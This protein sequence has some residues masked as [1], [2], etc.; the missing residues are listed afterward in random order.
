M[1]LCISHLCTLKII[2]KIVLFEF[3]MLPSN[4]G[5]IWMI[6][7]WYS[8]ILP[9]FYGTRSN[10]SLHVIEISYMFLKASMLW[11][12]M[13]PLNVLNSICIQIV[14][15]AAVIIWVS[16]SKSCRYLLG[17]LRLWYCINLQWWLRTFS[18]LL[19]MVRALF[20]LFLK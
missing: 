12:W 9:W 10:I 4:K 11:I 15:E 16:H 6:Y 19:F 14:T 3:F 1:Y 18:K 5:F 8:H 13:F 17:C 20:S 7:K 2:S